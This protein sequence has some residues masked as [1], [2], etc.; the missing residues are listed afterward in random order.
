MSFIVKFMAAKNTG[1]ALLSF[2]TVMAEIFT[3]TPRPP[4]MTSW[5]SP[6]DPSLLLGGSHEYSEDYQV[7]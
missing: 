6:A 1:P 4:D 3:Q 7:I 2:L 5:V